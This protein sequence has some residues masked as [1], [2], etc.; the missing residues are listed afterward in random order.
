MRPER[1]LL[2]VDD[3]VVVYRGGPGWLWPIRHAPAVNGVSF[4]IS[5]GE[6]L[7]LVGE[8]GSGKS[9][10]ARAVEGLVRVSSGAV[11]L[12]G[13]NVTGPV[14]GRTPDT[15]RRI[16][17]VFQNPDGSLNPRHSVLTILSRPLSIFRRLRGADLRQA[18]IELLA[19]VQ[20]DANCLARMPAQLSGGER[21][22]VAIARA[23]AAEPELLLCDEILSAL[24]VSVQASVI[25]LLRRLQRER[26]L[27]YLFISHDLSVVRWL[28]HRVAVLFRG[29]ICEQ[30]R[31]EDVFQPPFHP[32]TEMLLA[33]VPRLDGG[34]MAP[35]PSATTGAGPER[36]RAEGCP[37]AGR[38]PR[39]IGSI[40]D[41][42]GPPY[43]QLRDGHAIRCHIPAGELASLQ[44]EP[45]MP[46]A[47]A[48]AATTSSV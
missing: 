36:T 11:R 48:F 22:R 8:S 4:E 23:L 18:A 24:D 42:E 7:A 41:A 6:T 28:A 9:T 45:A 30:G 2:A 19:D 43:Q 44:T 39:R 15:K 10:I 38:C 20:L 26:G 21:Q 17:L 12:H 16:Q 35:P 40:C 25:A 13:E 34:S 33:A 1:P 3:L 5:S 27:A 31:V 37:F 14:R 29:E 32:Y 47:P 46:A